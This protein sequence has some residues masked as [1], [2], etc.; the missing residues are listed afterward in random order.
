[1]RAVRRECDGTRSRADLHRLDDLRGKIRNEHGA[2][3]FRR[4]PH[5][6]AAGFH[7]HA[8]RFIADLERLNQVAV[9]GV[10]DAQLRGV[11]VGDVHL[12]SVGAHSD[13]LRIGTGRQHLDQ[14]A[15]AD[16]DDADAIGAAIGRRQLRLVD[17][18]AADRRSAEG[19]VQ[20]CSIGAR[21]DAAGTL[22]ERDRR[23]DGVA[24]RVDDG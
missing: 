13:L 3:G 11:F 4:H 8:L 12:F 9:A 16:V 17:V 15:L 14:F 20:Q 1:M 5:A 10:D 2:V 6:L 19:H 7:R 22:A 24:D 18:R 21:D 23:N